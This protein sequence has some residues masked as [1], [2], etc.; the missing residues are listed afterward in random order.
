[1]MVVPDLDDVF[2]PLPDDLLVNLSDSRNVVD[3]FLDCLPTMFQENPNV[4]SATGP[5]LKAAYMVMVCL[6]FP[7]S[8]TSIILLCS[9][10]F[11]FCIIPCSQVGP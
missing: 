3:S 7:P 9:S 6:I 8:F 4:E 2:L 1:M 5:A 10:F 11:F